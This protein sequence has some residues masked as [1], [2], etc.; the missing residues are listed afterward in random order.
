MIRNKFHFH[1]MTEYIRI[2]KITDISNDFVA[3]E[4]RV[5]LGRFC[6]DNFRN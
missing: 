2:S 3:L 1:E 5:V 4:I 6:V